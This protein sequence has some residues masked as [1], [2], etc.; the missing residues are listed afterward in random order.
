M[1]PPPGHKVI[2]C[3]WVLTV[4]L[5]PNGFTARYKARLVAKGHIFIECRVR[6]PRTCQYS[7]R[8]HL[9]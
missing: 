4:K 5:K 3:K 1:P 8:T 7:I 2:G 9:D 6:I